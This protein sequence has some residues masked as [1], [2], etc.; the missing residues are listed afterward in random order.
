MK[1][2][3]VEFNAECLPASDLDWCQSDQSLEV[4]EIA[5]ALLPLYSRVADKKH[6]QFIDEYHQRRPVTINWPWHG[7]SSG[8]IVYLRGFGPS[9]SGA[10]IY[11]HNFAN[12]RRSRHLAKKLHMSCFC[13]KSAQDD[14]SWAGLN[15]T[16]VTQDRIDHHLEAVT[17]AEF[18]WEPG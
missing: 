15:L 4:E 16:N 7:E 14:M 9:G 3:D 8:K 11:V 10:T 17:L 18:N 2:A 5:D 13:V 12:Q 6:L 1:N